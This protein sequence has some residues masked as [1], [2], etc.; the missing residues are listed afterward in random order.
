MLKR[1]ASVDVDTLVD[2]PITGSSKDVLG[3]QEVANTLA[4]AILTQSNTSTITLGIDGPWGSGKSSILHLLKEALQK[5]STE[6]QGEGVGLIVVSFSP[7]LIT[8][9]TALITEFFKQLDKAIAEAKRRTGFFTALRKWDTLT[10]WVRLKKWSITNQIRAARKAMHK[11]GTLTTLAST[12]MAAIDPTLSVAAAAGVAGRMGKMVRPP[13]RSV[14]ELKTNLHTCLGDIA[15]KDISFRILVLIDDMDRLDP[16]DA[17][18]VLRLVKAVAD[19]PAVNYLLCYDREALA[20]SLSKSALISDGNAYLEK[21]IQFS[22]KVPPLEPFQLRAWLRRGINDLFPNQIQNGSRRAEVVL[23]AWAGRLLRTP[24]DVKRLLFAVRTIWPALESKADLLDLVWLQM[25]KEK[26]ST[27][28][29]NLYS[30]LTGYL[31]S[32][33]ALAIGGTVSGTYEAQKKLFEI[34]NTLGWMVY[35]DK[36]GM[37]SIDF[38]H[39]DQLLAGVTQDHLDDTSMDG[40]RWIYLTD[41]AK[42]AE[43][44]RDCRLSSPWHWRLYFALDTP[45]HA[46][47]DDEWRALERSGAS[48][49]AELGSS[50]GKLLEQGGGVR[51]DVGD[52]LLD[53][54]IYAARSGTMRY[55]V[56][57]IQALL[58]NV[59]G[60]KGSSKKEGHFGFGKQFDSQIKVMMWEVFRILNEEGRMQALRVVFQESSELSVSSAILREQFAAAKKS[61]NDESE[62]M[63]LTSEE[64]DIAVQAHLKKFEELSPEDFRNLSSPYD[65]LYAWKEMDGSS[66]RPG[67][68]LEESLKSDE[69]FL[70]T[71]DGLKIVTSSEQGRV[72]HVPERFLDNFVDG[73]GVRKRLE[74]MAKSNAVHSHRAKTLLD[75]W[76]KEG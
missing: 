43:L 48:S 63:F 36:E 15:E 8:D 20:K 4:T 2:K 46:L 64:L 53:R 16:E 21:I 60:L 52:Q 6:D 41:E 24:R 33:D 67:G 38:H 58:S 3:F 13:K 55:S 27:D 57:W 26:A 42:L 39:L 62:E 5:R 45:S 54:V 76:W 75:L 7:W 35:T 74:N 47:T 14:E 50:I 28:E 22:F 37:S 51:R 56:R 44:R 31:Q 61:E 11:F 18:E 9:Q 1:D 69:D 29:A 72:P 65:V 12:A 68:L 19:F 34:I 73:S 30:W 25:I 70:V 17:L 10:N 71:L 23:D 66:E 59:Q 40:T 32:L 49:A